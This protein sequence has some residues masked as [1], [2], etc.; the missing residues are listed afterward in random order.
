MDFATLIQTQRRLCAITSALGRAVAWLTLLMVLLTSCVVLLRYGFNI[1]SVALQESVTYLH[2]IVFLLALAYTADTD[3]HVR[4]DIF[5]RRFSPRTQ[6]WV[7]CLG[8]LVFL[9]PFAVY[10]LWVTWPFF[11][12]AWHIRETS[13]EAAGLPFVYLLKGL[14]PLAAASLVLQ[15]IG[16]VLGQLGHLVTGEFES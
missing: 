8:S 11:V 16:Q 7:N 9:L 14:L 2:G 13:A 5:Y 4:V 10:L 12:N 1:G 6:A 3:Q 15:A